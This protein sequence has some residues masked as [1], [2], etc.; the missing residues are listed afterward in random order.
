MKKLFV[1]AAFVL[2]AICGN[3]Q[4]AE[5]NATDE[6]KI[7]AHVYLQQKKLTFSTD[8]IAQ[9]VLIEHNVSGERYGEIL[10]GRI[11]GRETELSENEQQLLEAIK[12]RDDEYKHLYAERVKHLCANEGIQYQRFLELSQEFASSIAFQRRAKPYFD[13]IIKNKED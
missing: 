5:P 4:T 1:L 12:T 6:M 2:L 11:L 7:F 10:R 8:E 9:E 13:A 3:A